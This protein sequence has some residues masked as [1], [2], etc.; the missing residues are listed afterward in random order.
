MLVLI[1]TL[2]AAGNA[3]WAGPA[4]GRSPG[5]GD[6]RA[7]GSGRYISAQAYHHAMRAELAL[8]AGQPERAIEELKLARVY[9]QESLYLTL[10]LGSALLE[11]RRL[12]RA[13]RLVG[14]AKKLAPGAPEALRFEAQVAL[15]RGA[16]QVAESTLKRV[17]DRH[18]GDLEAVTLYADLLLRQRRLPE[19]AKVLKRAA[20]RAPQAVEPLLG[21][22]RV[23]LERHAF[24][25]AAV[26]LERAASRDDRRGDVIAALAEVYHRLDRD[27]EA[28]E[29]LRAVIEVSPQDERAL[30]AA[31]RAELWVGQ[32]E[33]AARWLARLERQGDQ[34]TGA[35]RSGLLYAQEGRYERAVPLLVRAL[36][37]QPGDTEVRF[38]LVRS[39]RALGALAEALGSL[40][41]ISSDDPR[42]LEARAE[43]AAILLEQGRAERAELALQPALAAAPADP[44]LLATWLAVR[45]ARGRGAEALTQLTTTARAD[46][47]VQLAEARTFWAL[48]Q[49]EEAA[50]RLLAAGTAEALV[51]LSELEL[52]RGRG[53]PAVEA[54]R[55]AEKRWPASALA[56][57]ALATHLAQQGEALVDAER[58]ASEALALDPG[59]PTALAARGVVAVKRGELE[60]AARYWERARR[61]AP[62][63]PRIAGLGRAVREGGRVGK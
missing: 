45:H 31:A 60:A 53:E 61:L 50:Q 8:S 49:L 44:R 1:A 52:Q 32:E 13:E 9:D 12:D 58:L 23:E 29:R 21:L 59:S 25:A 46:P 30:L 2:G 40:E 27:E 17:V 33:R 36:A 4:D 24:A 15:A 48:G 54:L 63:D 14:E 3:A 51:A 56:K 28:A 39:Q 6:S 22:A 62:R 11:A 38:E 47:I 19:A 10:R 42:H 5:R 37:A 41:L 55:R 35:R 16:T 26:A 43:A 7:R 18:P 57:A 20:E 34:G